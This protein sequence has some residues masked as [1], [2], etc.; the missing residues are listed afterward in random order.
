MTVI[1]LPL[2]FVT[3]SRQCI[4]SSGTSSP[5]TFKYKSKSKADTPQSIFG[6]HLFDTTDSGVVAARPKFY[7]TLVVLSVATYIAAGLAFW[8]VRNNK[9]KGSGERAMPKMKKV[10]HDVDPDGEV[11]ERDGKTEGGMFASMRR[12]GKGNGK[13]KGKEVSATVEDV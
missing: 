2:S 8:L 6:M 9:K 4:I 7:V 13:G 5:N 1:Y 11:N 12:R 3:V 10:N